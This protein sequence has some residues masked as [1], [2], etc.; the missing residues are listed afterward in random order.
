MAKESAAATVI[1]QRIKEATS[2]LKELGLP[3]AQQNERS[4]LSLLALLG[5]K[6]K[7]PWSSAS[8]ELWGITPM[9]EF[10]ARHYGKNYKP[11]TRETVRRQ[12]VHQFLEAGLIV[13][14]PDKPDRPVNSPK[15]VYR[16]EPAALKLLRTYGTPDWERDL[17][18]WKASVQGLRERYAQERE[19]ARIP[20]VIPG[21]GNLTLSPGGQNVLVKL[22]VEDFGS[23]F[24]PGGKLIYVGDTEDKFALF[25]K[26]ALSELGVEVEGHGKMPDIIIH[27]L[28]KDWLVLI[29]AVT[30][31]GPI[32][33]KRLD[34]L[35]RLFGKSRAGL[36][37]VTT[38][39]NRKAMVGWIDQIAWETEVWVAD[40][41]SHMIHFNGERFLGPFHG[42]GE[43][44]PSGNTASP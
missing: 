32:D 12:T 6:P 23:R 15:A 41:P 22:V 30:S 16:I 18:T 9:M 26:D 34:E 14:N 36:V 33:G 39:L 4:A 24:T 35:R 37:M 8:E 25:D 38:F 43:V 42:S 2:I 10:F 28:A 3:T 7:A 11:N 13:A 1:R 17:A 27:Y 21:G 20:V 5:L 19:M 29:E 40:S 44:P 31:H